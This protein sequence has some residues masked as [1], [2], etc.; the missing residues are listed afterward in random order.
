M[1]DVL[2]IHDFDDIVADLFEHAD[3]HVFVFSHFDHLFVTNTFEPT[4]VDGVLVNVDDLSIQKVPIT[5]TPENLPE[6]DE[7]VY[8]GS[9]YLG[10]YSKSHA[11]YIDYVGDGKYAANGSRINQLLSCPLLHYGHVEY[12]ASAQLDELA[13]ALS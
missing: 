6:V 5:L 11:G 9:A 3:G 12:S 7:M 4:T 13:R 1:T 2:L 10:S 8:V